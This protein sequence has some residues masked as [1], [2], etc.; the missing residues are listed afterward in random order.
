MQLL[1]FANVRFTGIESLQPAFDPTTKEYKIRRKAGNDMT[2]CAT[3]NKP[4]A[5]SE[6]QYP[7]YVL[8]YTI[9]A[10]DTVGYWKNGEVTPANC[11]VGDS[12]L[13][14]QCNKS[15]PYD[16]TIEAFSV[17]FKIRTDPMSAEQIASCPH[18]RLYKQEGE[19]WGGAS[20]SCCV[21][22]HTRCND[23][24]VTLSTTHEYR[25]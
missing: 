6:T 15:N 24:G 25:D 5:A 1:S 20:G 8:K 11:P 23:C 17:V 14:I 19:W 22:F 3:L 21:E 18:A 13:E 12:T 4:P 9:Y 7:G 2:F 10:N 16:T